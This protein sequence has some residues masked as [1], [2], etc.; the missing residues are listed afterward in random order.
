MSSYVMVARARA[1]AIFYPGKQFSLNYQIPGKQ[2]FQLL[3]RT[4]YQNRGFDE[5][6]PIDLWVEARGSAVSVDE[7]GETFGNA[8]LEICTHL[9][10]TANASMGHLEPHLIFDATPDANEHQ[11]LQAFLPEEPVTVVPGRRI[12]VEVLQGF[13]IALAKHPERQRLS[14]ATVQYVEALRYWRRGNEIRCL[15]HLYMG[16]DAVTKAVLCEHQRTTGKTE[17]QLAEEW[18]ASD[19]DKLKRR[20]KLEGQARRR[21][22]FKS[23]LNCEEKAREVSN[24]FEHGWSAFGTMRAPAEEIVGKTAGYLRRAILETSGLQASLLDRALDHQYSVPRGPLVLVRYVRGTLT[25]HV[26]KLAPE[27][28]L[29]PSFRWHSGLEKVQREA[30]GTFQFTPKDTVTSQFGAGVTMTNLRYEVWD[31]TAII[32]REPIEQPVMTSAAS[33]KAD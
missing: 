19:P 29:Y 11:F 33:I 16:I 14:N 9:A 21:L 15:A 1:S 22:I 8:A 6:V 7:A 17:D 25:G 32:E 26:D 13:V 3:F 23:D 10:L 31:G 30:N 18:G 20:K 4:T 5:P 28:E 12:D 2:P 27:G 24:Q